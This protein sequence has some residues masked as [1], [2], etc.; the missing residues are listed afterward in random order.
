VDEVFRFCH[1]SSHT[2]DTFGDTLTAGGGWTDSP[3]RVGLCAGA[4][5]RPERIRLTRPVRRASGATRRRGP[6]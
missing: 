3:P 1:R 6:G 4:P 5:P 2:R